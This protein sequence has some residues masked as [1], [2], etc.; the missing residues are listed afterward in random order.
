[1]VQLH[2]ISQLIHH[3]K[4]KDYTNIQT[5]QLLGITR[6]QY[7]STLAIHKAIKDS[8][9]IPYLEEV[10]P[11]DFKLLEKELDYIKYGAWPDYIDP[12][13]EARKKEKRKNKYTN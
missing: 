7:Y 12:E 13:Q 11:K 4:A 3:Y 2:Y 10:T 1:L 6:Q 5:R 9:A 8:E